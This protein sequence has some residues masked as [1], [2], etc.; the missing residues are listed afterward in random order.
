MA[1]RTIKQL[2]ETPDETLIAEHDQSVGQF[3]PTAHYYREELS[4]R[5]QEKQA[6]SMAK[7]TRDIWLLTIVVTIATII[8]LVVAAIL[9]FRPQ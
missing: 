2:R 8:N 9:L 7:Y 3:N 6:E 5:A 1:I 4:R